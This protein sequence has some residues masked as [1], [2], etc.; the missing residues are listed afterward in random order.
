MDAPD[1]ASFRSMNV[2]RGRGRLKSAIV[3]ADKDDFAP[4]PVYQVES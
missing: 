2:G 3:R 4:V 1:N